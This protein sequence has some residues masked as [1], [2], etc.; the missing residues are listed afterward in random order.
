MKSLTLFRTPLK[1][2]EIVETRTCDRNVCTDLLVN[3]RGIMRKANSE[4]AESMD[5]AVVAGGLDKSIKSIQDKTNGLNGQII[6]VSSAIEQITSNVH[7]FDELIGKQDDALA[8]TN[9]TME[10][11]STAV[12]K[13]TEVT[14]ENTEAAGKLQ[15]IIEKGGESVMATSHAIDEATEAIKAVADVI[16]IIDSIAAQTN[17]LSMNAAIEA[18]HAGEVGKGF[19]VVAGEIRKLAESTTANSKSIAE[20][21]KK[22]I[23]QINEAKKAGEGA[24]AV[25]GNIQKD[26]DLF[27]EAFS[28]ISHSTKDLSF[29]TNQIFGAMDDLKQISAEIFSGSKEIAEGSDHINQALQQ[30]RDYSRGLAAD[31]EV[32]EEKAY[33]ISGSQS[34]IAQ[35]MVDTNRD[36]EKFFEKMVEGGQLEKE[37]IPFN[38]DLI[39]L[40]HRNWLIRL[41]AFLDDRKDGVK[42]TSDDYM[43]CD[44]GKWIYGNGKQ[45]EGK[46]AYKDL[47]AEHKHFH[48]M[49]G[50]I[51]QEKNDDHK[52]SA[53]EKYESLISE[54]HKIVSLLE[55]L[56][57]SH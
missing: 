53:E 31:M 1:K 20:S 44:L 29:E 21:L 19:A 12:N 26:V 24:G 49:A 36:I 28:E 52:A 47:E 50:E 32:I 5:T 55:K 3:I 45:F 41:R 4:V 27:V 17:L 30:T 7:H 18:A 54:Y 16:K 9:E 25:F 34:G 56:K 46:Q 37:D 38:F 35:Y 51:I 22:I 48:K 42:A 40:M 39:V 8:K 43:K 33:D 10:K 13:V 2:H 15:D 11:V 6:E 14:K 57:S 23:F